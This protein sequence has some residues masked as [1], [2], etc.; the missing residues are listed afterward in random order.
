M[1]PSERA[2]EEALESLGPEQFQ[3]LAEVYAE[4]E[5]PERFKNQAILGRNSRGSTTTGWPDSYAVMRDGR[6]DALE[7]TRDVRNWREHLDSDIEQAAALPAPGLG[8]IAFITLGRTPAP[9]TMIPPRQRLAEIGIPEGRQTFVFRQGLI[10]ALRNGRFAHVWSANLGISVSAFPFHDL[11][12]APIYGTDG[13]AQF[14]PTKSE[15]AKGKVKQPRIASEVMRRLARSDFSYVVGR[16]ASG[17]TALAACIGWPLLEKGRPVYYVDLADEATSGTDFVRAAAETLI[18]RGDDGVLFIVDNVH[19]NESAAAELYRQWSDAS[20]GAQL[21]LLGRRSESRSAIRGITPPLEELAKHAVELHVDRALLVGIHARLRDRVGLSREPPPKGVLKR[22][23]NIFGGDMIAFS[24]A[25]SRAKPGPPDWLL[26]PS[27]ARASIHDRYL[28][29]LAP[30]EQRA[31]CIVADRSAFELSTPEHLVFPSLVS[32]ALADGLL[33]RRDGEM[34]TIHPGLGELI[35]S[36]AGAELGDFA[37]TAESDDDPDAFATSCKTAYRLIQG[38]RREVGEAIF[39]R[40]FATGRSIV[41]FLAVLDSGSLQER[42]AMLNSVFGSDDLLADLT[43]SQAELEKFVGSAGLEDLVGVCL[44]ARKQ[45]RGARKSLRQAAEQCLRDGSIDLGGLA[46]EARRR[47]A[48]VSLT[49]RRFRQFC[50]R[51]HAELIPALVESGALAAS[52]TSRVSCRRRRWVEIVTAAAMSEEAAEAIREVL[53]AHPDQMTRLL[54][55]KGA[56]NGNLQTAIKAPILWRSLLDHLHS[57]A[58]REYARLNALTFGTYRFA[59]LVLLAAE[60]DRTL[61]GEL[62]SLAADTESI[63]AAARRWRG[64]QK[65][66]TQVLMATQSHCLHLHEAFRATKEM[67]KLPL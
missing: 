29:G 16:G 42:I 48:E 2:L 44:A 27:D 56:G 61:L 66:S 37:G 32:D 64:T 26:A 17:K 8:G 7:A 59:G 40:W 57:D 22:W 30:E 46:L 14:V 45:V 9:A 62:D 50:P 6:I 53:Q 4:I 3:R 24:V 31:L 20:D 19:R 60:H 28:S 55:N 41:D 18:T 36:A 49:L 1:L 34:R 38:G 12:D 21:L 51:L 65:G 33:E 10:K 39:R 58:F 43:M 47:P 5:L 23:E 63:S 67:S 13:S 35:V 15:H 54:L 25:L 52:A 11:R